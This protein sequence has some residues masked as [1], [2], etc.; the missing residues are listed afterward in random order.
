M[1]KYLILLLLLISYSVYAQTI[2]LDMLSL[3]MLDS[4]TQNKSFEDTIV[5]ADG[6]VMTFSEDGD[7]VTTI[8]QH[9]DTTITHILTRA[10][11]VDTAN[12]LAVNEDALLLAL[13]AQ[14]SQELHAH[15]TIWEIYPHPL[16]MYLM[17]VP[18]V[19]PSLRDT[20][21]EDESS[22]RA[23]RNKA[24]RYI[25][26]HHAN[27]Y[28]SMSDTNRLKQMMID[29]IEVQ[30]AIV[31]DIEED[32]LDVI[33]ALRDIDSRWR[34]ELN[35]SLQITQNYA[36][37]NWY[38]GASNAFSMLAGAKGTLSY[39]HENLSW[40]NMGEWRAGLST[41]TGDSLRVINTT[42]DLFR[43]NSKFG[44]QV[45]KHWYI[46]TIGEFRTNLMSNYRKNTKE[47]S[48]AFLTPV[49]FTLGVGVDYKPIKNLSVNISPATYKMVYALKSDKAVVNLADFGIE[50]GKKMLNEFGSSLRVD[51]KWRPLREIKV[52]TLFYFFTNYKRIE[53]E[54]ELD[55]DFIINRYLSAKLMVHPRYDST[56][57]LAEGQ[58]SKIQFKE[59][60]SVGFSHTFR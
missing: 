53:T 37:E 54:L 9:G 33:R 7:T 43:L 58:K 1:K 26:T 38:Q 41:V 21:A 24:R 14:Q 42:D 22:I 18:T 35:V 16:C 57:E 51:W 12:T 59:L 32:Q 11:L 8:L 45:H 27:Y 5:R 50:E 2:N 25:T 31:K 23:I 49:R 20:T 55:I 17:Y 13:V 40:E 10:A 56:I 39:K 28:V 19:Y 48:S 36:S 44:F 46:S 34:K 60:I 47:L 3:V 52:E 29:H 30:R 6:S 15:D 4:L